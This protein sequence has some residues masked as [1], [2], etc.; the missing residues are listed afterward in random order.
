[1]ATLSQ[2]IL[3]IIKKMPK[4]TREQAERAVWAILSFTSPSKNYRKDTADLI[5]KMSSNEQIMRYAFEGLLRT[6]S[7]GFL[8]KVIEPFV[9]MWAGKWKLPPEK[10]HQVS[11][12]IALGLQPYVEKL[13]PTSRDYTVSLG[14]AAYVHSVMEK[15]KEHTIDDDKGITDALGAATRLV[16]SLQ[17]LKTQHIK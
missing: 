14:L 2:D 9:D 11:K 5:E 8:A 6:N 12:L 7:M 1:M 16:R 15:L 10:Y 3:D 17:Y 4:A 13:N